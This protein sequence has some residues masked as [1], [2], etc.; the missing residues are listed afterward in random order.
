M[1]GDKALAVSSHQGNTIYSFVLERMLSRSHQLLQSTYRSWEDWIVPYEQVKLY[2]SKSVP[3]AVLDLQDLLFVFEKIQQLVSQDCSVGSN[4][5][6]AGLMMY[7]W[8]H[9]SM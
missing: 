3:R 9:H 6:M 2:G 8:H 5:K 4:V 7:L 1:G